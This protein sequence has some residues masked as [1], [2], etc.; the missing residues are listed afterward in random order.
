VF[1]PRRII[2][3]ILIACCLF[4]LMAQ[5][6]Q[7]APGSALPS[8]PLPLPLERQNWEWVYQEIPDTYQHIAENALFELYANPD[9]LA[10]KVV[11]KRSGYIWHSNLD[12]LAEGDRLNR[13]WTAFASSGI[14]IDF[15]DQKA[16]SKRAS[17][18]NTEHAIDFIPTEQGFDAAVSFIEPSISMLVVVRLGRTRRQR[19]NTIFRHPPEQP[20]VQAG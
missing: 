19:R 3:G 13:T 10:F 17:I 9:T 20:P 4:A 16:L 2:Q 14:S 6:L 15:L 12:E 8:S 7:A 1:K 5:P 11:D 18:T